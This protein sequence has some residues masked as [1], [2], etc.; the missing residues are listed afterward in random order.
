MKL[1]YL[2][3]LL[4]Y[5]VFAQ[6]PPNQ[7]VQNMGVGINIGNVLSAP[8]EGNWASP[9]TEN[10]IDNVARL[11][12]KHVRIPIRFDNQT[13][14][15]TSVNYTNANGQY[16]GSPNNYSVNNTYLNRV[17]QIIDWCLQRNLVAIID[18]HGDHWFWESFDPSSSNYRTGNDRLAAIDRFKAIWRDISVR[19]QNKPDGVLF[20]IMNEPFFSMNALEVAD[21][22]TQILNVIRQTNPTRNVIVTGGGAN[23][24][25]APMQ[26]PQTFLNS[27]NYLIATF[28]YYKPFNFTSSASEQYTDNDWGSLADRANINSDFNEVLT[29]SQNNNIPV[30]LGEFGAD[31]ANGYNYFTNTVGSFG[32]PD[33]N[34][35][36]QY[37]Q[38]IAD[39]ARLRGFALAVW[40]AGEKSG[41]TL[42]LNSSQNWVKDVRNAVLGSVCENQLFLN[43][44]D[45]ECNYDYSWNV[46]FSNG[47]TGRLYN[48]NYSEG[49]LNSVS[50]HLNVI[51]SN[52]NH[53][54]VVIS[55]EDFTTNTLSGSS[56]ILSCKA[57]GTGSTSF[58][59]RIRYVLNGS[60]SYITSPINYLSSQYTNFD[61]S[62]SI[63]QNTSQLTVQLLT[64]ESSGDY[65]FDDFTIQQNVLSY[66]ETDEKYELVLYPNPASKL[67]HFLSDGIFGLDCIYNSLGQKVAEC[68][69][70]T[71]TIDISA[72]KNGI[73]FL[74][75]IDA[76]ATRIPKKFIVKN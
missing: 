71:N 18:V 50:L 36:F 11:R 24:F 10:Y 52:G 60:T 57:K 32:G 14:P 13:T 40:D 28:H 44:A 1:F 25:Q 73:Y 37:H 35:R 47:Y 29:W 48:S 72:L 42:Y 17:E 67:I 49:Y 21:I 75:L 59:F 2:F 63:P 76:N 68:I 31:N 58:K 56:Y 70:N 46:N 9:L 15:F 62:F 30:Y 16:I 74:I 26:L 3:F 6:I 19:F 4:N 8:Y 54:G 7:M 38:F 5:I 20:E 66:Y 55:N 64:G 41:K 34:S 23:S 53:D 39:A 61:F 27:D 12:F 45:I 69:V 43:N 51:N 22:N 65:F 33:E